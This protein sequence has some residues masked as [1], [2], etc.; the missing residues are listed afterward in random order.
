MGAVHYIESDDAVCGGLPRNHAGVF[1]RDPKKVT[2]E[3]CLGILERRGEILR[4]GALV[5]A[6]KTQ[7]T[8]VES[9]PTADERIAPFVKNL[10]GM[11][12]VRVAR[13]LEKLLDTKA[14]HVPPSPPADVTYFTKKERQ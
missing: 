13:Y 8:P 11:E 14:G 5:E 10:S 6:M 4:T 1:A 7:F 9:E 12:A 3:A 2:C